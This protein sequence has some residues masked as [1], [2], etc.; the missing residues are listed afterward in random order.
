MNTHALPKPQTPKAI[1][2]G[3]QASLQSPKLVCAKEGMPITGPHH[4]LLTAQKQ[5]EHNTSKH[6]IKSPSKNENGIDSKKAID[7]NLRKI[8]NG[9]RYVMLS[10]KSKS[11]K[12]VTKVDIPLTVTKDVDNS[13]ESKKESKG[14]DSTI[15]EDVM[16]FL[17]EDT[18]IDETKPIH[19]DVIVGHP[20]S[21]SLCKVNQLH[22]Y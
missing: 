17:K 2:K 4:L 21:L 11:Q 14:Q 8:R 20:I 7:T 12:V 22:E 18:L 16:N 5:K 1:S 15:S 9:T 10:Q 3:K 19:E 6:A 13:A